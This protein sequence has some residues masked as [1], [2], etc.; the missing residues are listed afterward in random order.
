[1][2][3][4][5]KRQKLFPIPSNAYSWP[6]PGLGQDGELALKLPVTSV[7]LL[8]KSLG[9]HTKSLDLGGSLEKKLW[10]QYFRNVIKNHCSQIARKTRAKADLC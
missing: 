6:V 4:H 2:G 7:L 8:Y 3:S 10:N 1:M 9:N 5:P